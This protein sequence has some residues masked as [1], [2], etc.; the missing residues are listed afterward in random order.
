MDIAGEL[1]EAGADPSVTMQRGEIVQNYIKT[2]A[3]LQCN[4]SKL[5]SESLKNND[6]LRKLVSDYI[7]YKNAIL[8]LLEN[9]AELDWCMFP[10][11]KQDQ[12]ISDLTSWTQSDTTTI[13]VAMTLTSCAKC[14]F[15][16]NTKLN[17][18]IN[19]DLDNEH[20]SVEPNNRTI[21]GSYSF[22]HSLQNQTRI[23]IRKY[24]KGG[25]HENTFAQ[26]V[27]SLPLPGRLKDYIQ[28]KDLATVLS[29]NL[30]DL[31]INC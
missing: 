21:H 19:D 12:I 3:K 31:G 28:F 18:Y 23:S 7:A 17:S 4:E 11:D 27:K 29:S 22:S 26:K 15:I 5:E 20:G 25:Y 16:L 10:K 9:G 24:L 6:G 8:F 30:D 1:I 13:L 2:M 14:S